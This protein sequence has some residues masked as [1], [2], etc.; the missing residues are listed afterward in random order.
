MIYNKN[1]VFYLYR[2]IYKNGGD[3]SFPRSHENLTKMYHILDYKENIN[4]FQTLIISLVILPDH[5]AIQL[6]TD[7]RFVHLTSQV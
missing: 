6:E 7:C 1:A 2:G 5:N 3:I 4:K